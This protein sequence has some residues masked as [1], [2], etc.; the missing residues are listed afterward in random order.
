MYNRTRPTGLKQ[1]FHAFRCLLRLTR[2]QL[3]GWEAIAI[4]YTVECL[5]SN[6]QLRLNVACW[7]P[8]TEAETEL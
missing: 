5:L 3:S 4:Q 8:R 7:A 1:L 6:H 2:V